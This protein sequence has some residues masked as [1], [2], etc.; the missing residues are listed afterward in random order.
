LSIERPPRG[1]E[2]LNYLDEKPQLPA[3]DW[4]FFW[5]LPFY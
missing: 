5:L 2:Y 4:G 3:G 1:I